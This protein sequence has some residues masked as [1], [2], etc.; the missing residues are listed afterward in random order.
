MS[1]RRNI[2]DIYEVYN[3]GDANIVGNN[4]P[5]DAKITDIGSI[6]LRTG[7]WA[8]LNSTKVLHVQTESC[9]PSKIWVWYSNTPLF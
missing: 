3:N 2:V 1:P 9:M 6:K 7:K 8:K 4:A 5:C